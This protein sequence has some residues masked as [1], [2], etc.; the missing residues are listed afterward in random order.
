[1]KPIPAASQTDDGTNHRAR[2][3]NPPI[4][5]VTRIQLSTSRVCSMRRP[6]LRIT[7]TAR[8]A[9]TPMKYVVEASPA[10]GRRW[11]TR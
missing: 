5:V 6:M 1:V 3:R 11:T 8:N 10:S 7:T 4:V 2:T 9:A